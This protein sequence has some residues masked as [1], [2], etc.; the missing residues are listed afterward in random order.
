[1]INLVKVQKGTEPNLQIG[2][3]DYCYKLVKDEQGIGYG[4]I[5]KNKE[6]QLFIFIDKQERG[7]G[8]GKILFSKMLQE[9]KN[10]GYN[11]VKISFEKENTPM[12]KIAND[13][14]ATQISEDEN[15]VKYIISI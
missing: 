3:Y 9:T 1:M 8:Y 7:N 5:N 2:D 4:T 10:I 13:N 11:E 12:K 15:N 6:N 14:G